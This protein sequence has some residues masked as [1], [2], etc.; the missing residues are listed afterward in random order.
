MTHFPFNIRSSSPRGVEALKGSSR[1]CP[2]RPSQHSGRLVHVP[3]V[4]CSVRL[5]TDK[6]GPDLI[7]GELTSYRAREKAT[8][9]FDRLD[10]TV[11]TTSRIGATRENSL[12]AV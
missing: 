2:S 10:I 12:T 8:D 5:R 9:W 11:V 1:I 7:L 6:W 4:I 3:F